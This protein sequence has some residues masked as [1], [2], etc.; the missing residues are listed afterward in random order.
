MPLKPDGSSQIALSSLAHRI[1]GPAHLAAQ[2]R[3][4]PG[5]YDAADAPD[6]GVGGVRCLMRGD[7]AQEDQWYATPEVTPVCDSP[8]DGAGSPRSAPASPPRSAPASPPP[9]EVAP[10]MPHRQRVHLRVVNKNAGSHKCVA[11][12]PGVST[13]LGPTDL[14]V[15]V[16]ELL[17]ED[18]PSGTRTIR[19]RPMIL[20][21]RFIELECPF[22]HL[23]ASPRC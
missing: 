4:M 20:G 8:V 15:S 12:A 18:P 1:D 22:L 11:T 17:S 13:R 21:G 2:A 23:V 6:N 10:A 7:E 9:R 14:V 16:H 19:S 3:A 5:L